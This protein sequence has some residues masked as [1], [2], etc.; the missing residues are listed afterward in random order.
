MK[1]ALFGGSFDPI[2]EGHLKVALTVLRLCD[3]S[4]VWFIPNMIS[5]LKNE[6]S[7]SFDD[8]IAL[9]KAMIRPYRKLKVCELEKSLAQPSKS[10]HTVLALQKKYPQHTFSWVMGE[11]QFEAFPKWFESERL[12]TLIDFIGVSRTSHQP[13][14]WAKQ[15]IS[16]NH[17]AS[18][19]KF[20]EEHELTYIPRR[21]IQEM[22]KRG[23]YLKP[24]LGQYMSEKR[25]QHTLRVQTMAI[26]LAIVHQLDESQIS[27]SALL[28]DVAKGMSEPLM[29]EWIKRSPYRNQIIPTYAKHAIVSAM[30]AKHCYGIVDKKIIKAI[31]HHTEG[32]SQTQLSTCLFVA[33][34]IEPARPLWL[35]ALKSQAIID[36]NHTKQE[37]LKGFSNDQ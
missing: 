34:K 22:L 24:L 16:F 29:D 15:W 6:V 30:L 19:T 21:V 9:I 2:H 17:P 1:I 25:F 8:R 37:I 23:C 13:Y 32:T 18:A 20:R 35:V 5:P 33:D 31:V 7:A 36:L 26:K 10:L 14:A 27:L 4:E 11:D 3:V 12:K 28:H